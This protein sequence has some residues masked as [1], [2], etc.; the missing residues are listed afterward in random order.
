MATIRQRQDGGGV[1]VV[2]DAHG[3]VKDQTHF[4]LTK[5]T[6]GRNRGMT[7]FRVELPPVSYSGNRRQFTTQLDDETLDELTKA[8]VDVW[9]DR[10]G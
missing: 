1:R 8:F 2:K 6:S 10:F 7:S 9:S 5:N 3:I 4:V